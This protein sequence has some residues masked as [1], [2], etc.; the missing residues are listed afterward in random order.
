MFVLKLYLKILDIGFAVVVIA[1]HS[2]HDGL[3]T[4]S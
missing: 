3:A 1:D 2:E 4:E